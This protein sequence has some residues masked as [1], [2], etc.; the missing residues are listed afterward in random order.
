MRGQFDQT[1]PDAAFS[2]YRQALKS[3]EVLSVQNGWTSA[4]SI[5]SFL[6]VAGYESLQSVALPAV[7]FSW[8]Q[9]LGSNL[10][11]GF[12]LKIEDFTAGLSEDGLK[13][14]LPYLAKT[15]CLTVNL[16]E[17]S[18]QVLRICATAS[19]LRYLDL[20]FDFSHV[21]RASDLIL[22]V[23]NHVAQES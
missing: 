20:E 4:W 9:N 11:R 22:F 18:S 1:S 3:L 14:L 7:P 2:D 15:A 6:A 23:K 8:L 16:T 21:V 12:F 19:S 5:K 17:P 13:L 10:E